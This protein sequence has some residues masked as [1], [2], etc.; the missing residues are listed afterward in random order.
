MDRRTRRTVIGL[1]LA[2]VLVFAGLPLLGLV[3]M[4]RQEIYT[5]VVGP[6]ELSSG[7]RLCYEWQ[8]YQES[9]PAPDAEDLKARVLRRDRPGRPVGMPG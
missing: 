2:A 5:A 6:R 4:F 7:V 3:I 9:D 8:P 1:V